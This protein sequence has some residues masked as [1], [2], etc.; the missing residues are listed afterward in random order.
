MTKFKLKIKTPLIAIIK[1]KN[2]NTMNRHFIKT[3]IAIAIVLQTTILSAQSTCDYAADHGQ[4]IA[5]FTD[6]DVITGLYPGGGLG[7]DV[8]NIGDFNGDGI[9]DI[10]LS[11]TYASPANSTDQFGEIYVIFGCNGLEYNNLIMSDL[12]GANGFI[13]PGVALRDRL[14]YGG[15]NGIGDINGD[16][17]DDLV[18]SSPYPDPNMPEYYPNNPDIMYDLSIYP[19]GDLPTKEELF[20]SGTSYVIFGKQ[21]MTDDTMN[22]VFDLNSL[23]ESNCEES[24]NNG[25]SITGTHWYE[26]IGTDAGPAG[27]FNNDGIDDFFVTSDD[28]WISGASNGALF[29][30]YGREDFQSCYVAHELGPDDALV[31]V[32][33]GSENGAVNGG[34][35]NFGITAAPLNDINGDGITDLLIGASYANNGLGGGYV[36]FGSNNGINGTETVEVQYNMLPNGPTGITPWFVSMYDANTVNEVEM[37]NVSALD[38]T[39]GFSIIGSTFTGGLGQSTGDAGDFNNDGINDLLIGGHKEGGTGACYIIYGSNEIFDPVINVV[40]IDENDPMVDIGVQIFG[41]NYNDFFGFSASSIGDFNGDTADDI[42]VGAVFAGNNGGASGSVYIIYGQNGGFGDINVLNLSNLNSATLPNGFRVDG[43]T[44]DAWLGFSVDGLLDINGD[45]HKEIIVGSEFARLLDTPNP[46]TRPSGSA[47]IL[48]SKCKTCARVVEHLSD[49]H[50]ECGDEDGA[51]I[52]YDVGN[53]KNIK[54]ENVPLLD[55]VRDYTNIYRNDYNGYYYFEGLSAFET[56]LI[57]NNCGTSLDVTV[58]EDCDFI[59]EGDGEITAS[60]IVGLDGYTTFTVNITPPGNYTFLW[61]DGHTGQSN[62]SQCIYD[63]NYVDVTDVNVGTDCTRRFYYRGDRSQTCPTFSW[64][65]NTGGFFGDIKNPKLNNLTDDAITLQPNPTKG[66]FAIHFTDLE[67][68][69]VTIRMY[70]LAGKLVKEKQLTPYQSLASVD[71][72][73]LSNGV[74]LVKVS[75]NLGE[76]LF[77]DKLT[78]AH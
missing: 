33:D 68:E 28:S 53:P 41:E 47:Y 76:Q 52:V 75:T 42:V 9:D 27:D 67:I 10:S 66:I 32:G 22:G 30:I 20:A 40:D 1:A 56:N 65:F 14:G 57:D 61:K 24:N 11:A 55:W 49:L 6:V 72:S 51:T 3:T 54:W 7:Y 43:E 58:T 64:P 2:L 73:A 59:C 26:N 21:S 36:I 13:I 38:G 77:V 39:N 70:D 8:S 63:S 17:Y 4:S 16:G 15:A 60:N 35:D 12:D 69:E 74:Y 44:S 62:P 19:L 46:H 29:L 45:S 31:I 78:I 50:I 48:N 18:V 37:L 5:N 23:E 25:F 71:A 34:G